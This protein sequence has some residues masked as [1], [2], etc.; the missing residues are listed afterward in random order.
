MRKVLAWVANGYFD[1][2]NTKE[3]HKGECFYE[4]HPAP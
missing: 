2:E 1:G 3:P 4:T